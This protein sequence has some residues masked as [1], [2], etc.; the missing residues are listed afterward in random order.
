MLRLAASTLLS[1]SAAPAAIGDSRKQQ[2]LLWLLLAQVAAMAAPRAKCW[3]W[4]T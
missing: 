2:L 4:S 3:T 1:G